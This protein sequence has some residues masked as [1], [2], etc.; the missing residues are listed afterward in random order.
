MHNYKIPRLHHLSGRLGNQLFEWAFAIQS[1]KHS[2][3]PI[4]F[5]TDKYHQK[6]ATI[7]DFKDGFKVSGQEVRV[8]NI[9][10][11]GLVLMFF[12]KINRNS[13]KIARCFER[14]LCFY[15]SKEAFMFPEQLPRNSLFVTGF[16]INYN[17][18]YSVENEIFEKLSRVISSTK[19]PENLSLP[20][21]FQVIHARRGDFLLNEHL[22][23]IL[24]LKYYE[25]NVDADLPIILCTDDPNSCQDLI[26]LLKITAVL[27][28]M[29]ASVWQTLKVMSLSKRVVMSNSTLAWWGSFL[30]VKNGGTATVP[31]PFYPSLELS[32]IDALSYPGFDSVNSSFRDPL[33]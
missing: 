26:Q 9:N 7:E 29:S 17:A 1:N 19:L 27:S 20:A 22:F 10:L 32:S 12:D 23:G 2:G 16:F 14:I 8:V 31:A 21:N 25:D 3:R 13:P 6:A 24:D 18:F 33:Q 28:P 5:F 30:C 15:R 11:L 4:V